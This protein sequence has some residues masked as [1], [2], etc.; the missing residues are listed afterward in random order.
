MFTRSRST[1]SFQDQRPMSIA[2]S[3]HLN[4]TLPGASGLSP[5]SDFQE[6]LQENPARPNTLLNPNDGRPGMSKTRNSVFG[7]DQLWEKEARQR[8]VEDRAEAEWAAK[9]QEE[10]RLKVA[11]EEEK[12]RAK[13]EKTL[14][15]K[16]AKKSLLLLS[17]ASSLQ[18]AP[19]SPGQVAAATPLPSSPSDNRIS[20]L[21]PALA[22]QETSPSRPLSRMLR[23]PGDDD[24]DSDWEARE[25]ER[26]EDDL[27]V[28]GQARPR[29]KKGRS[30][31][32]APA[33][34]ERRKSGGLGIGTW[35]ASSDEEEDGD[36]TPRRRRPNANTKTAPPPPN[37]SSDTSSDDEVPLAAQYNLSSSRRTIGGSS[38][39][40]NPASPSDSEEER[41]LAQI[42][43]ERELTNA[44]AVFYDDDDEEDDRPLGLRHQQQPNE[45]DD[46]PLGL[47]QAQH[48]QQIYL[49]QQQQMAT[50]QHQ[51]A[52]QHQFQVRQSMMMG[53]G[54]GGMGMQQM[55]PPGGGPRA[56]ERVDRWRRGVEGTGR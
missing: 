25:E 48:L 43:R 33:G 36:G 22:L 9:R 44:S 6:L 16:A 53:M 31:G 17:G 15:K 26:G 12:K 20:S 54:I 2:G 24:S 1:N 42:K 4:P 40:T 50:M 45:D 23:M 13:L 39:V 10:E 21:P 14:G 7:I 5:G 51:M 49:A 19:V 37:D 55:Q 3:V 30:S 11:L 27:G 34:E 41:P 56:E 47:T 46:L 28:G 32:A 18:L 35:F 38:F 8:E 52:M 29:P